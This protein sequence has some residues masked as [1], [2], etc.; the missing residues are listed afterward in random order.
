MPHVRKAVARGLL[1]AGLLILAVGATGARAAGGSPALF[2]RE[3]YQ[4]TPPSLRTDAHRYSVMVM[5][6]DAGRYVSV[7]HRLNPRLRIL[8]YQNVPYSTA[9]DPTGAMG[10]TTV[11][12]DV[13]HPGWLDLTHQ[14]GPIVFGDNY[15]TDVGNAGYQRA[16][17]AHAIALAKRGGFNGILLDNVNAKLSYEFPSGFNA[18]AVQFPS[19][20]A[21]Q[22]AM[23][24]FLRYAGPAVRASGLR[25]Y[26]NIGGAT[27]VLWER[28]NGPLDG[29]EEESWT[30]ADYGLVQQVPWWREKLDNV[31][32]SEAHGKYVILHSYTTSE[33]A[34]TY[35]LASMLLV[36]DGHT[37]YST[38]N[39]NY[40]T[41]A[42]WL[43]EYVA[44]KR[45]GRPLGRYRIRRNGV[46]ERVFA[47][48]IVLVNPTLHGIRRFSLGE[49]YSGSGFR[50]VRAVALGPLSGV[51]LTR[52]R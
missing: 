12:Q 43:P 21:W 35:G 10:C 28:W 51:I 24:S 6:S 25:L 17:I 16:C 19:D 40:D 5:W 8:M 7:L 9:S 4:V 45:L 49:R 46:Y 37:S 3:E 32:W 29:A 15:A 48:G 36:A 44:A 47:G 31:A 2:N 27:H 26:A 38:S 33:S 52:T 20:A 11:A 13:A 14:G 41:S 22:A 42:A 30:D 1:P 39:A 18:S 23:Y 34:N 50:R